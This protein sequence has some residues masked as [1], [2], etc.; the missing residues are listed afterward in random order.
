MIEDAYAWPTPVV[1]G[2][3]TEALSRFH[4]DVTWTGTVAATPQTPEMT[5]TGQGTF[6]WSADRLWII[7]SFSQDQFY[8]GRKVT[9]WSAHY[10]VG[11]DYSR[12]TYVAFA[13]DSNGRAVSFTGSIQ[14][15][16]FTLTSD[17]ATIAGAPVRLRMVWDAA[18]PRNL[19][20][21]NEISIAEGPWTLVE[22]YQ[23]RPLSP[24]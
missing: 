3:E 22:E 7:G 18:D 16:T 5:A 8:R 20:W 23:M 10:V 17:G 19:L 9:W 13:A 11:Y 4:R 24:R 12:K 1:P 14:G 2:P 15:A 6:R 21:R